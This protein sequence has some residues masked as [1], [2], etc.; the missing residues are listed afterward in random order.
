MQAID[1]VEAHGLDVEIGA[2]GN[3]TVGTEETI[4]AAA[5]DAVSAAL[6]SGASR[7]SIQVVTDRSEPGMHVGG[8]QEALRHLIDHVE[9]ELGG[10]L[11]SL[12]REAKQAAVKLL[13]ER[14]AFLLRGAI[15][16]V[17][18]SMEVSR[19]TI[20]NYLNATRAT[21]STPPEPIKP[22]P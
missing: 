9:A 16:D 1:A 13:E 7:V 5:R 3:T 8:L 14:G 6:S 15:E 20:Y 12:G 21:T 10:T 4:A 18:A 2:F 17:A 19:I 22:A 11:N